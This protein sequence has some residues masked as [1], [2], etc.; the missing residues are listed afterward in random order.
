MCKKHDIEILIML[1]NNI[2]ILRKTF[3]KIFVW[4]KHENYDNVL[5]MLNTLC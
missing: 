5:C 1:K 4:S 3:A 2:K